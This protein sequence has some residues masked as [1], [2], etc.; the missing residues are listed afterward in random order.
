M[1]IRRAVN[2]LRGEIT[3]PGDKSISHRAIMLGAISK[4]DT[5]IKGALDS[6][7]CRSTREIFQ[8]MGIEISDHNGDLLIHGRGLLNLDTSKKIYFFLSLHQ[9]NKMNYIFYFH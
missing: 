1:K 9:M 3:V 6:A 7:D 4:G 2:P 5:Y 8:S